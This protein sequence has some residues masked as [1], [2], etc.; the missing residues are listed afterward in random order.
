MAYLK[1]NNNLINIK[2][3]SDFGVILFDTEVLKFIQKFAK[4]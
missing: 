3:S 2:Q 4:D 1:Q